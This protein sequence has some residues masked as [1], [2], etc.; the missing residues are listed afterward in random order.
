[1][2]DYIPYAVLYIP[3]TIFITANLYFLIPFT[4]SP[5]TPTPLPYGNHKEARERQIPYD[6][7]Y[8]WILKNKTDKTESTQ[9]TESYDYLNYF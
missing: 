6:F 7:T 4:F 3:M 8:M 2:I 1:M 9:D 5:T